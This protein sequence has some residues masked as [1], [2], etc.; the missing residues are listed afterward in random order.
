MEVGTFVYFGQT[1]E[2]TPIRT[3]FALCYK[4]ES[5]SKLGY[6][7]AMIFTVSYQKKTIS[8]I[9]KLENIKLYVTANNTW[10]G[11][12]YRSWPN[13][14][15]P[16]KVIGKFSG[17]THN[18][19][20]VPIEVTERS[21]L[22]GNGNY[23]QCIDQHKSIGQSCKSIFHPNSYKYENEN[24]YVY[25]ITNMMTKYNCLL[26]QFF[27]IFRELCQH[28]DDHNTVEKETELMVNTCLNQ[29][30]YKKYVSEIERE[31]FECKKSATHC[32][33]Q[34]AIYPKSDQILE[35]EEM[36][37]VDNI[38]LMG[39]LGGLLGLFIGF[40]VFGY[41]STLVEVILEKIKPG[42]T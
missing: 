2:T 24:K 14:K 23:S 27:N 18:F 10:Q 39:N 5:K 32:L 36:L 19:Y 16:L 25:I 21:H 29:T 3:M 4:V 26:I 35:Y 15:N 33:I 9:D 12:I 22:K 30:K 6:D 42:N 40:S 31:S 34:F 28:L 37:I 41:A 20:Y 1:I 11:V 7:T 17:G 8:K 38:A 13:T